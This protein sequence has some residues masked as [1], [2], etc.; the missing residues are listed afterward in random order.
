MSRTCSEFQKKMSLP[1]AHPE[2]SR[3]HSA[4]CDRCCEPRDVTCTG[5]IID[6]VVLGLIH[7][8]VL[9]CRFSIFTAQENKKNGTRSYVAPQCCGYSVHTAASEGTYSE[10][11]DLFCE[12]RQHRAYVCTHN[13]H[14]IVHRV[15]G[16]SRSEKGKRCGSVGQQPKQ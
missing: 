8:A 15:K 4:R 5:L 2:R 12:G 13:L 1:R 3:R 16:S 14:V 7:T 11:G 6:L 10:L 9:P